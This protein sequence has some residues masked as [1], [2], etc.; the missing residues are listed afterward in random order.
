M[1]LQKAKHLLSP[2]ARS[3]VP[4]F[5]VMDVMAAAARF[6]FVA[7]EAPDPFDDRRQAP[8]LARALRDSRTL[9]FIVFWMLGNVLFGYLAQPMGLSSGPVAWQAHIG[10]FAVGFFLFGL[11]D[12]RSAPSK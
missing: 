9:G 4:P 3:G 7:P 10:G 11:F 6:V 2:S 8:S 5:M 1:M 12:P